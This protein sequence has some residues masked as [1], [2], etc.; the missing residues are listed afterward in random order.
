MGKR[1]DQ[2]RR[3]VLEHEIE[4]SG[5]PPT[6]RLA[7]FVLLHCADA[8]TGEIPDDYQPSMATL[9]ERTGMRLETLQGA[10]ADAERRGWLL[11]SRG[12][13]GRNNYYTVKLPSESYPDAGNNPGL[14]VTHPPGNNPRGKVTRKVTRQVTRQN[15]SDQQKL[16]A[17]TSGSDLG[18]RTGPSG[19]LTA[20]RPSP[21]AA[22][23]DDPPDPRPSAKAANGP[24]SA[25]DEFSTRRDLN[26]SGVFHAGDGLPHGRRLQD[27]GAGRRFV[28]GAYVS[29][30]FDGRITATKAPEWAAML[31]RVVPPANLKGDERDAEATARWLENCFRTPTLRPALAK[32]AAMAPGAEANEVVDRIRAVKHKASPNP[33]SLGWCQ[34]LGEVAALANQADTNQDPAELGARWAHRHRQDRERW[35]HNRGGVATVADYRQR[36]ED[37]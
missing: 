34:R 5:L 19:P 15:R 24:G 22:P 10:L 13:G 28:A 29:L 32:L 3:W 8:K 26:G 11:H 4:R 1:G 2:G 37:Q 6:T 33:V 9:R 31:L 17:Q 14:E 27:V 12:G 23:G 20:D 36:R 35:V 25:K 21:V 16:A 30:V 7:L 18:L